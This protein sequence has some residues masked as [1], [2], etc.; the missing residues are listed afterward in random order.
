MSKEKNDVYKVYDIIADWFEDHRSLEFFE[1]PYMDLAIKYMEPGSKV[2]DLGCGTGEPIAKYFVAQGYEVL[3]VDG[4][5]KLIAK[6]EQKVPK[7]KFIVRDMRDLHLEKKFDCIIAWH[8][9]FHLPQ[10]D[11]RNMFKVF[12]EHSAPGA[13]LLFTSGIK[14]GEVWGENGGEALYHASLNTEE[15][16]RLLEAHGFEVVKHAVDDE[17][18]GGATVWVARYKI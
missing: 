2:L 18:C 16:E 8:S 9:F 4:S 1:K 12:Q 11:Q 14:D 5:H 3:G 15:Y 10:E 17:D 6:A 13:M 7:A